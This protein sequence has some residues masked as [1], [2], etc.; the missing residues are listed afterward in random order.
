MFLVKIS[1]HLD[2]CNSL[3][4]HILYREE[5]ILEKANQKM[6]LTDVHICSS[7]SVFLK[8]SKIFKPLFNKVAGL[9]ETPTQV[10]SRE[11]CEIFKNIFFYRTPPVAAPV[12]ISL[13][14]LTC[15][16]LFTLTYL[17]LSSLYTII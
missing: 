11:I 10:L 6:S 17:Y 13:F 9:L 15:L 7:K 8:S 4:P 3:N 14:T 1:S 2:H 12:Y 16:Y 5:K